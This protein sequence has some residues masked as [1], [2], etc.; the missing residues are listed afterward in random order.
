MRH[1]MAE[2]L[3]KR[4]RGGCMSSK[5]HVD[6]TYVKVKGKWC[7]LYRAI[8]KEG[9]L[10]DVRL[11]QKRDMEAVKA[12][13]EKALSTADAPPEQVTTDGHD[14]YPRAIR[15]TLG[16]GSYTAPVVI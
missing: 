13:F 2:E 11:S 10:I 1:L 16:K 8:D 7:Y 6:E 4:R 12:F 5:W 15:E 14:S 3:R 9:E